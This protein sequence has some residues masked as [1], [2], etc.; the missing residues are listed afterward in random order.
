MKGKGNMSEDVLQKLLDIE[1]IKEVRALLAQSLDYRDWQLFESL[2][3]EYVETDFSAY[4][5]PRQKL[6]REE[7]SASYRHNLS[8]EGLRTQHLCTNFRIVVDGATAQCISNFVGQHYLK[9]FPGGE[10]FY[11]RAEYTDHLI[12]TEKG[13][14]IDT[15][16]LSALFYISGNQELLAG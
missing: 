6:R 10:E 15:L 12:R 4:G 14:K 2:F 13:W 7:L 1:A 8:R 11:L 16:I 9:G 5:V 3:V